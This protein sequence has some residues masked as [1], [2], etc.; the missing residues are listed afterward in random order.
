[1]TLAEREESTA[2]QTAEWE[3][4]A[5]LRRRLQLALWAVVVVTIVGGPFYPLLGFTVPAVTLMGMIGGFFKGR[6][7]CGW[8]CPRGAF[9]DRV[10]KWVSPGRPIPEWLRNRAFRWVLF[11]LLMGSIVWQISLNPGDVYHWGKVF[12]RICMITTGV[13]VVLALFVHPRTW[14]AFCPVGTFQ[15]AVGRKKVPLHME[16]GCVE[17]R[18]CERACPMNLKIVGR[19]KE[20][21][22]DL[23]DCVK[24][25]ECQLA[26]PKKVLRL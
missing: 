11:G 7:V 10:M 26:C 14:C 6:Y 20:G 5:R 17:C 4:Q 23:P 12:V 8:L 21:K 9:Y 3:R 25:S 22:V 18:S 1:M 2:G 13:G 24:C 15:S 16:E 19:E